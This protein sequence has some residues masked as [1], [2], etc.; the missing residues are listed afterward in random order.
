MKKMKKLFAL[1]LVLCLFAALSTTA[2]A[3]DFT[4]TVRVYG[5]N[6]GTVSTEVYNKAPGETVT[7]N[8]SSV[9][10][11]NPKYIVKGFRES[12]KGDQP[13]EATK[14]VSVTK[15]M[16]FVVVYGVAGTAVPYTIH[17][18]DING[19]KL[20]D[21]VTYY[22]N[23][24]DKPVTSYLYIEGY[25]PQYRQITGTLG[26]GSNEW[27]FVYTQVAAGGNGN[28][29]NANDNAGGNAAGGNAAGGNAAGGNAA[30][31]NAAG[32][33]AAGGNAAGGN[34]GGDNAGTTAPVTEDI[35]D[36]DVPQAGPNA[37]TGTDGQDRPEDGQGTVAEKA[38]RALSKGLVIGS[39]V[40]VLAL[41]ALLFWYL[42]VYRKKNSRDE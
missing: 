26:S 17:Y 6:M 27:T 18:V 29:A 42:L 34:A 20:A 36:L 19:N 25:Q 41:I 15:D 32:E 28:N 21:D 7:L 3:A 22:G 16:D 23:V 9:T 4:Y 38:S 11:T 14:T 2:F 5:G 37:G 13:Y 35:L 12:G 1:L 40:L 39:S 8:T 33:N 30:G 10:V 24:G 31:G